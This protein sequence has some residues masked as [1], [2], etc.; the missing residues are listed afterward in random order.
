MSG[1]MPIVAEKLFRAGQWGSVYLV[2]LRE[3]SEWLC[4]GITDISAI[5][6]PAFGILSWPSLL[7][8]LMHLCIKSRLSHF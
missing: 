6:I 7:L 8:W 3:S 4:L 5:R 1:T 2:Q